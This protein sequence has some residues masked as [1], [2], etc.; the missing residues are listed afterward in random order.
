[1]LF[2][3][4]HISLSLTSAASHWAKEK[5][6]EMNY[7]F[8]YVDFKGYLGN[9]KNYLPIR[10]HAPTPTLKRYVHT[11]KESSDELSNSAKQILEHL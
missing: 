7:K 4:T 6:S 3:N 5:N 10:N 1:M 2:L 9:Q 11:R 8:L